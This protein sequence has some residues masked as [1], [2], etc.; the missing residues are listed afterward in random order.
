MK[1][2][3]ASMPCALKA[4]K[5]DARTGLGRLAQGDL[6]QQ[7]ETPFTGRLEQLRMD[8]NGSLSTLAAKSGKV[9]IHCKRFPGQP[10]TDCSR[11]EH[12]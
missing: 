3:S 6:S 7:I 10:R 12:L 11:I 9:I 8:F 4:Y 1:I 5:P 2:L